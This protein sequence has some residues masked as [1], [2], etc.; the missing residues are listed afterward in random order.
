MRDR[1]TNRTLPAHLKSGGA[2]PLLFFGLLKPN[3]PV[4]NDWG[5][6]MPSNHVCGMGMGAKWGVG[7]RDFRNKVIVA[8]KNL[9]S[10]YKNDSIRWFSLRFLVPEDF[11]ELQRLI[12]E[13]VP[14]Q[15]L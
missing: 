15:Y 14:A 12:R 6:T 5:K 3:H 13:A 9:P 11:D 8:V 2:L 7:G 1:L 10:R 4:K